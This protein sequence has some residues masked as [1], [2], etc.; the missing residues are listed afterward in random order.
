M[1]L[2][3]Y[4][5]CTGLAILLVRK[6]G[7]PA[8]SVGTRGVGFCIKGVGSMVY[9]LGRYGSLNGNACPMGSV[10]IANETALHHETLS[11]LAAAGFGVS[12]A[13]AA[14][15]AFSFTGFSALM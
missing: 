4:R 7:R 11:R 3:M 8:C 12:A 5:V 2:R 1:Y 14:A 10:V 9:G 13:A 15:G 6:L